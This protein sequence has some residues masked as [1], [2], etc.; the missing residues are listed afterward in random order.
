VEH[1]DRAGCVRFVADERGAGHARRLEA[2]A[3][4]VEGERSVGIADRKCDDVDVRFHASFPFV[5]DGQV[6]LVE[7]SGSARSTATIMPP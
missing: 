7:A 3:I 1:H 2:E 6:E 4:A 5:E